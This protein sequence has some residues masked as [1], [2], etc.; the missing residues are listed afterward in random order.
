[1]RIREIGHSENAPLSE[2]AHHDRFE[3]SGYEP[4]ARRWQ[5]E[6][7]AVALEAEKSTTTNSMGRF[8]PEY[9]SRR[10]LVWKILDHRG[11]PRN[12][13]IGA[14]RINGR[15]PRLREVTRPK[16]RPLL[17]LVCRGVARHPALQLRK[18]EA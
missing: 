13:V 3:G 12:W 6:K 14:C 8:L 18:S 5:I 15:L 9:A 10:P 16:K 17:L 7:I 11:I 1:M 2:V 4:T